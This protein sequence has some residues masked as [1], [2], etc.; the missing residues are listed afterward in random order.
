LSLSVVFLVIAAVI[1]LYLITAYNRL[2]QLRMR[3]DNSWSQID[4]Q[5]KRRYDLIPN[6]VETVK[7]YSIHEKEVLE[8]VTEMRAAAIKATSVEAQVAAENQLTNALRSVFAVAENYPDLK[9]NENF[10]ALQEELSNT[11]GKI[12]FSRQFYNDTV[13]KYNQ[14]VQVFPSNIVASL[15]GFKQR[16]YFEIEDAQRA[17]V[18]VSFREEKKK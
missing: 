16:N 5:L 9:A 6:L 10:K 15:F 17:N 18:T 7:G 1:V 14:A 2:V 3:V 12:A 8:R 11:E 13:M 4:V